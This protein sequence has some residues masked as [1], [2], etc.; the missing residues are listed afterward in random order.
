MGSGAAP[1]LGQSFRYPVQCPEAHSG[2]GSQI[3]GGQ[4]VRAGPRKRGIACL[5]AAAG[6]SQDARSEF[7]LL[8]YP[9][10]RLLPAAP[11]KFVRT[12][13]AESRI[14]AWQE[15]TVRLKICGRN[16]EGS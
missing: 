6:A 7:T 2:V 8:K 1:P 16:S 10:H 9:T 14:P 12:A 15:F 3:A 5:S 13:A 11:A 4:R